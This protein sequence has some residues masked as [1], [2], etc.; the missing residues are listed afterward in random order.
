MRATPPPC[1]TALIA[2]QYEAAPGIVRVRALGDG[3]AAATPET[4]AAILDE[5]SRFAESWLMPLNDASDVEGC[6]LVDGRVRTATGHRDAWEAFVTGG[7]STL[8]HP[9]AIGGQG[10]PLALGM[11]VQEIFDRACPAFGMLP[12]PQRAA[13]KL[14]AAH[15]DDGLRGE[16]LPRLVSGEWGAT[17]CISEADAGSDVGRIRTRAEPNDDG[18]W[19]ITGEKC[20]ISFG[21]HDLTPRIGHCLLARTPGAAPGGAGLSLFLVP[22][23]IDEKRTRNRIV[24]RRI[25][26]KMGLHGSPTCAIGFEGATGR[27][28]GVE[29]R[30]L[31]QMFVM[32]TNMRLSVGAQGLGIASAAADTALAYARDRR[33]GGPIDAPLAI[34]EHADVQQQLIGAVARVETLRGLLLAAANH[35]ELAAH[36]PDPDARADALALTQWLLPIIKTTGGE[37]AFAVANSA[38]QVLGG[39]GYT[40]EWPV[41]QAARDAR[42]LTIYEGTTG[43]QA[44]DLTKRRLLHGDRRGFRVFLR[45]ARSVAPGSAR[46]GRCLDHLEAAAQALEAFADPRAVEA[47]ATAFLHLAALAATGWI[48]M[49][50]SAIE[51][52]SAAHRRLAAAGRSWIRGIDDRAALLATSVKTGKVGLSDFDAMLA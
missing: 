48:A 2:A 6:L 45:E 21:D 42:V 22:D 4:V 14:I 30:G 32:I 5:A 40:R 12:V 10:L 1:D 28:I 20:W 33:Q 17:I 38:I 16:W 31:A 18:S 36:D 23:S 34:A 24:T 50:L 3:F 51:G 26:R 37:V 11:A 9:E 13:A 25:E 8:D 49:R 27:L 35:A 44:L 46:F 41:E 29:G 7:W 43:I 39:A 19:S 15:G 52:D 47:A